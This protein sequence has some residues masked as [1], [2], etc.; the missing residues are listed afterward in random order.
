MNS[1]Q[2]Q[3]DN[4]PMS[5]FQV[6][7]VS[8]CLAINML[9]GYDV[10]VMSFAA[11]FVAEE[12]SLSDT[13]TG[14]LL[15]S[16]LVGMALGSLFLAPLADVYG[17]RRMTLWSLAAVTAGMLASAL[18]ADHTQLI[19]LRFLT[20][21]GIGAMLASLTVVVSEYSSRRRRTFSLIVLQAGFPAGALIWGLVAV[22]IILG[23]GWRWAFVFG[24]VLSGLMIPVALAALPES[25]DY[26]I[27]SRP[28]RALE[29]VNRALKQMGKVPVKELE[30]GGQ[31]R[32]QRAK[33]GSLFRQGRA[34]NTLLIWVCFFCT[35][36]VFYF[37]MSWTPKLL[38]DAGLSEEVG[39]SGGIILNAG[40][41]VGGI[42][43]GLLSS[44]IRLNWLQSG[45]ALLG[46]GLLIAFG[47]YS[48]VL[49]AA[50]VLAFLVGFF[51]TGCIMGAY[52]AVP[53]LYPTEVR[54]TGTG[55]AIGLGRWGG[56]ASPTV[57]GL[58]LDAGWNSAELY[59]IFSVP[60]F[61]AGIAAFLLR[62]RI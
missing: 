28:P 13:V 23:Y 51:G 34:R 36:L 26:L 40:A 43:L 50:L 59:F 25:L 10:L 29:K 42:V 12:W 38:I 58:L 39:L 7:A 6:L 24:G 2:E 20:G 19:A 57:A 49:S 30:A 41:I 4:T 17:R 54:T 55:M 62:F 14:L 47:L 11:P 8:V 44:R 15:S 1:V 22:P 48:G 21:I 33:L 56:V 18:A 3:I 46:G 61:L 45:Y 52:A 32:P 60:L 31:R 9:D 53:Q 37:F 16:G 5:S 35:L 27:T